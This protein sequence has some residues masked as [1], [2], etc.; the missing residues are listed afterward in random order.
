MP[1][2]GQE[3]AK[4]Q[5]NKGQFVAG[6]K[7]RGGRPKGSKNKATIRREL[8]IGK[9]DKILHDALPS[10][11]KVLVEKAREGDM[12]AMKMLLDRTVPIHKATEG[13][14]SEKN[15]AVT[16]TIQNLTAP[17]AQPS[18]VTVNGETYDG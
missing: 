8:A 6:H 4:P 15:N 2:D 16:I 7:G 11:L 10:V 12:S 5:R 18:G 9:A 17:E 1:N 14:T 3:I 13:D